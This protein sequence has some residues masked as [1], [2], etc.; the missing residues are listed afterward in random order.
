[1]REILSLCVELD[2]RAERLYRALSASVGPEDLR[3]T[4]QTLA[5]EERAHVGWWN[6]LLEAWDRG[7]LP[8]IID[9]P[10]SLLERLEG[11]RAEVKTAEAALAGTTET[12]A[13]LALAARVEFFMLD[14]VFG[15]LMDLME[16]ART[17]DRHAAYSH[18]IEHLA[19]AIARHAAPD[20]IVSTLATVLQR[21]L[22]DNRI[23]TRYAT[24]DPLTG[25][26]NRR[27]LDTHLPQWLAWAARYGRP[28]A[29]ALVD[30]DG[31][32]RI[33]DTY[34]HRAGDKALASVARCIQSSIRASDVGLRYGGDE[35]V[36]VAPESGAA[37][38][39]ALAQRLL[40]AVRSHPLAIADGEVPLSVTVGGSVAHDPA[41]SRPRSADEIIAAADTSLYAAKH[42]GRDRA[43]DPV[44]L[45]PR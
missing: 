14:P 25:L 1:M 23:L 40:D 4:F 29:V 32:K 34:G 8:D 16:P 12:E 10:V 45:E 18:H 17:H 38:Y 30:L 33:N 13:A 28:I 2:G 24:K 6:E 15:E 44:T 39:L 42:A 19:G 22:A 36:V 21:T 37:E 26:R 43:G 11:I 41:G 31:L 35:F 3:A 7:L 27:A 20:S 5:G 9:D